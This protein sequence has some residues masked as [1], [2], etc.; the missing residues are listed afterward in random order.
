MNSNLSADMSSSE[1]NSGVDFDHVQKK[2]KEFLSKHGADPEHLVGLAFSGGGIRSATFNL[3]VLQALADK[4]LLTCFDYLSTVS[5]GGYIGAWLSAL[6]N[7]RVLIH[8]EDTTGLTEAENITP[9]ENKAALKDIEEELHCT[10]RQTPESESIHFLRSYSNYLTPR[11]GL[12]SLDT[13]AAFSSWWTNTVLNQ[14]I[15]ISSMVAFFAA[16]KCIYILPKWFF[17]DGHYTLKGI[18]YVGIIFIGFAVFMAIKLLFFQINENKIN[19]PL[20]LV[21]LPSWLGILL[22]GMYIY[23]KCKQPS[24]VCQ[25]ENFSNYLGYSVLLLALAASF[26]IIL[27]LGLAGRGV[28]EFKI[29]SWKIKGWK[30]RYGDHEWCSRLTGG[31]LLIGI[32]LGIVVYIA[33]SLPM[34]IDHLL[35]SKRENPLY[36]IASFVR[37]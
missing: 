28:D 6:I 23:D 1:T 8:R 18:F 7:R 21:L 15:L 35:N 14:I 20:I 36:R 33:V 12:F 2:E 32:V 27:F 29:F 37:L 19:S 5:G 30:L 16:I 10:H 24:A 31:S 11:K 26:L 17:N 13:L 25:P 22:A 9:K 3:G 4:K 34:E